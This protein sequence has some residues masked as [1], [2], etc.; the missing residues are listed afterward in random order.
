[1][2]TFGWDIGEAEQNR[3]HAVNGPGVSRFASL[4]DM[5]ATKRALGKWT[6][7]IGPLT[8]KFGIVSAEPMTPLS[9]VFHFHS[10]LSTAA[11]PGFVWNS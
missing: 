7:Q 5:V 9:E 1:M 3:D 2:E 6:A 8:R 11:R 10:G 4:S